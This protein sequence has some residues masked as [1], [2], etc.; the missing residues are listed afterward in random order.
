MP[1]LLSQVAASFS[2][3]PAFAGKAQQAYAAG[4]FKHSKGCGAINKLP[5]SEIKS[6][7]MPAM[8][9][10]FLKRHVFNRNQNTC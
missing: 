8:P 2:A 7:K 4:V 6:T 10:L 5:V 9:T 3:V 1:V